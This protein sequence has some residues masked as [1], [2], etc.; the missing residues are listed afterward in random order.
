MQFQIL[1][2]FCGEAWRRGRTAVSAAVG[3]GLG[4]LTRDSNAILAGVVSARCCSAGRCFPEPGTLGRP[5]LANFDKGVAAG[6]VAVNY[7]RADFWL[8]C[9]HPSQMET[10]DSQH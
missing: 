5:Q 10:R 6:T 7:P 4:F 1:L 2:G 8:I 9:P 3:E